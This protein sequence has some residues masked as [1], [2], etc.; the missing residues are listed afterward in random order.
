MPE[1]DDYIIP[2]IGDAP[3]AGLG[4]GDTGEVIGLGGI[5]DI[6]VL[7]SL[8]AVKEYIEVRDGDTQYDAKIAKLIAT[9]TNQISAHCRT[10]FELVEREEFFNTYSN[11]S[12]LYDLT[13]ASE[14]GLTVSYAPRTFKL[15]A[16]PLVGDV[17]VYYDYQRVFGDDTLLTGGN[18]DYF[19]QAE[20]GKLLI[21]RGMANTI[22]GLKVR[23]SGGYP[24]SDGVIQCP[25]DLRHGC[26]IQTIYLWH[27]SLPENVGSETD[28]TGKNRSRFTRSGML[29]SEA[30]S[31]VSRFRRPWVGQT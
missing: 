19:V 1:E 23:Y 20:E 10:K 17:K 16:A 31:L 25:D 7:A 6:P 13:G 5:L 22:R 11:G 9:A 2:S 12:N 29:S 28:N 27:R 26:V 15:A 24:V 4:P 8:Q 3:F 21:L 14:D 18:V 30:V